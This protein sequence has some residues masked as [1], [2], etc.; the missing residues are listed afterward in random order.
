MIALWVWNLAKTD[1]DRFVYFCKKH[2]V[3]TIY[4]NYTVYDK[5]CNEPSLKF[6]EIIPLIG[7]SK[8]EL[9]ADKILE[10]CKPYDK[11][12]LDIELAPGQTLSSHYTKLTTIIHELKAQSKYVGVDVETWNHSGSYKRI[13]NE[14]DCFALMSYSP[15]VIGT[16]IKTIGFRHKLF[17]VGI[18][19]NPSL[20]CS[21]KNPD[22]AIKY[23]D[24]LNKYNAN[25]VGVAVHCWGLWK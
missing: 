7:D 25:Y 23:F 9:S 4:L 22:V 24:W 8:D 5:F 15:T 14:A 21:M 2:N 19:T 17:F 3:Q 1:L 10:I 20:K 13:I 16:M 6:L 12:H 11:V 18:E